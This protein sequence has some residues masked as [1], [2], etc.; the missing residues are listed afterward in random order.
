MA[1]TSKLLNPDKTVLIP[2]MRAGCSLAASITGADVRLLRERY[3]RRAGRDLCQ[4]LRRREGGERH[5]LHVV[6][7]RAGRREPGRPTAS[8]SCPTSISRSGSPRR[9]KVKIIAWKGACEVHERFTGDELRD[10]AS[11]SRR[12]RSSRIPECPPDVIAEADFTG[13]TAA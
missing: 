6:E 10:I 5:L 13:S 9:P 8:S 11:R 12:S 3:P 4:H 2:D 1:E 7:R